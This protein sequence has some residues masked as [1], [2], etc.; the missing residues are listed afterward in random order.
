MEFN[1]KKI[2]FCLIIL[3]FKYFLEHSPIL[4]NCTRELDIYFKQ[5]HT[6][7]LNTDNISKVLRLRED[8]IV[9]ATVNNT[10]L[11]FDIKNNYNLLN[12]LSGHPDIITSLIQL[13][14][15]DIASAGIDKTIRVW[16]KSQDY[17][18]RKILTDNQEIYSLAQTNSGLFITGYS[19]GSIKLWQTITESQNIGILSP[20]IFCLSF[21]DKGIFATG[22]E[23]GSINMWDESDLLDWCISGPR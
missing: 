5:S 22:S 15:G 19:N 2:S 13:S 7:N 4:I 21:L 10:L 12:T 8:K 17:S 18:I 16:D 11:I 6:F 3:F 20:A 23:D 14:N 9:V 1:L